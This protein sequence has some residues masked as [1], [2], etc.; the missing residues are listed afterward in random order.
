MAMTCQLQKISSIRDGEYET[1]LRPES[2]GF[3]AQYFIRDNEGEVEVRTKEEHGARAE[4]ANHPTLL[5]A[6]RAFHHA[7]TAVYPAVEMTQNVPPWFNPSP[8]KLLALEKLSKDEYAV[9]FTEVDGQVVSVNAQV[10]PSG[11]HE[12]E[13]LGIM[14]P[15]GARLA[16][17]FYP[18]DISNAVVTFHLAI[19][20]LANAR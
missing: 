19:E 17:R 13:P 1:A 15:P 12:A 20:A 3:G 2:G 6:V 16:T 18:R 10:I 11:L 7:R 9:C 5:R 8:L 4:S 14:F